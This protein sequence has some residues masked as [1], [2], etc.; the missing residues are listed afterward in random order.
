MSFVNSY[1]TNLV[2]LS[3]VPTSIV[4]SDSALGSEASIRT[5]TTPRIISIEDKG[6]S[7]EISEYNMYYY[8]KGILVRIP[9]FRD[10]ILPEDKNSLID[11]LDIILEEAR[12]R[13]EE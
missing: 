6:S 10:I 11:A 5:P 3:F 12:K 13:L 1:P 7:V 9:K 8:I 4:T 2:K